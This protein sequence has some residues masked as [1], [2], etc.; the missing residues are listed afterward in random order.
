MLIVFLACVCIF[1]DIIM[2]FS[3]DRDVGIL[4]DL[5]TKFELDRFTNNGNLLLGR[6]NLTER[7]THTQIET[8]TLPIYHIGSSNRETLYLLLLRERSIT[9]CNSFLV[10]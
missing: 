4:Y 6:K 8:D 7:N 10:K 1:K 2:N 5:S 9:Y 3:E